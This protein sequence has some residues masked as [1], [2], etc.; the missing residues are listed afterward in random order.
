MAICIFVI[1]ATEVF[2]QMGF[3]AALIERQDNVEEAKNTTFTLNVVRGVIISLIVIFIA[4]IVA[5]YY[6]RTD[7]IN[8]IRLLSIPFII[9]GISNINLIILRKDLNFKKITIFE[10]SYNILSVVLTIILVLFFR[11]IWALVA[12]GIIDSF[13]YTG[14]SFLLIPGRP[15][16]GFNYKIFKEL[17][18]YG[19]F[20]TGTIIT[21][22]L[23]AQGDNAF[24]GKVLGMEALGYYVLAFSLG[25]PSSECNGGLD[26]KN[27]VS[28]I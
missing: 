27:H 22:F 3:M 7:L 15:R 23:L 24:V 26:H 6:E 14:L 17:F 2:T 19:K 5:N 8:I 16:F 9:K 4:P 25:E 18:S 21:M 11:N 13:L 20:V 10:I 12:A 1:S 28:G